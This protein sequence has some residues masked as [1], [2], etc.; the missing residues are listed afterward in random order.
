MT[1]PRPT[2]RARLTPAGTCTEAIE[3]VMASAQP[4]PDFNGK[5][6]RRWP[7]L[8]ITFE[9]LAGEW[10]P[11]GKPGLADRPDLGSSRLGIKE[12]EGGYAPPRSPP[13]ARSQK[14]AGE[15][16]SYLRQCP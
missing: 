1:P 2:W 4:K 6:G 7:M 8:S 12:K 9:I 10:S 5:Q 15:R 3:G 11:G 16:K 14:G 13:S